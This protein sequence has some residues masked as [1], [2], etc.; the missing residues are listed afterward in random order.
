[1]KRR[2]NELAYGDE[3]RLVSLLTEGLASGEDIP[4]TPGF[5]S[6]LKADAAKIVAKR[7]TTK[8]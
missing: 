6:E 7:K 2:E 1:M 5:W 3:A 4:L 8:K